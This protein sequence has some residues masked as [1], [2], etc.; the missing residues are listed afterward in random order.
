[1]GDHSDKRGT[2]R[3]ALCSYHSLCCCCCSQCRPRG[4]APTLV[5]LVSAPRGHIYYNFPSTLFQS[6]V[7]VMIVALISETSFHT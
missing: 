2:H 1:M 3:T 5:T 6:T 4:G 7:Q